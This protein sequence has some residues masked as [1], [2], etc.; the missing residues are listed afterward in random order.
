M[1]IEVLTAQA[2]TPERLAL[3]LDFRLLAGSAAWAVK[4]FGAPEVE[5]SFTRARELAAE[6]GNPAQV[7]VALRGLFGCYYA[8]GELTRAYAQAESVVALARENASSGDLMV[9]HM[10]CGSIRYWQGRF[11]EARGE[12]ETA[13]ALYDPAEQAGRLLSSQIDPGVNARLHLGWTLWCQGFPDQALATSE[14]GLAVAR[15][16]DQPFSLAMALFWNA[17][18][19]LSCGA[20]DAVAAAAEELSSVTARYQITYLGTCAIVL[21]GA[22]LIARGEPGPGVARIQQAFGAFR[23][24][25]AG[26]GLPWAMSLAAEGC[27]RTGLTKEALEIVAKALT[28]VQSNGEHQWEAELHRLKGA[29]L[30]ALPGSDSEQAEMNVYRALEIAR[31][32]GARSLELRAATTLAR[33]AMPRG[34]KDIHLLLEGL[35]SGFSEGFDTADVLVAGRLLDEFRDRALEPASGRGGT[36]DLRAV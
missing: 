9:G 35:Y 34:D 7:V 36:D 24:Q 33:I 28:I 1:A 3:E 8:R 5:Q 18:T 13:L 27:L 23:S 20:I 12:L 29:C 17:A 6:V 19:R 32:Q 10:L 31:R 11:G 15:R 14:E 2:D 21:D 22:V 26:L 16:I 4:G 25:Q 30:A